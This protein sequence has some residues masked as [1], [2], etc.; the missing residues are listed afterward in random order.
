[1]I[2]WAFMLV[3]SA[4]AVA[5]QGFMWRIE[6]SAASRSGRQVIKLW[7]VVRVFVWLGNLS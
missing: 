3:V 4:A 2:A 1:M 7:W 5:A 6:R